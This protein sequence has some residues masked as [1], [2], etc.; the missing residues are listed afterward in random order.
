MLCSWR[1][2]IAE[3]K[4]TVLTRFLGHP[5]KDSIRLLAHLAHVD[6]RRWLRS[7]RESEAEAKTKKGK[8]VDVTN[9]EHFL[10]TPV[11][12]WFLTCGELCIMEAGCSEAST[13]G[14]WEEPRHQ[15]G[16]AS[17]LHMGLTLF[18]RRDVVFEQGAGN[19]CPRPSGGDAPRHMGCPGPCFSWLPFG[20]LG[21]G[22]LID[23]CAPGPGRPRYSTV[24]YSTVPYDTLAHPI[25]SMKVDG[26]AGS[27]GS[28]VLAWWKPTAGT[29]SMSS[30]PRGPG[31]ADRTRF[32]RARENRTRDAARLGPWA[33]GVFVVN[34]LIGW[35]PLRWK[36]CLR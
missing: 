5:G 32:H 10:E 14:L 21:A 28:R 23:P 25:G 7:L 24:Q 20:V 12:K 15:D 36:A 11:T 33:W 8:K 2:G 18:G 4:I 16:G 17:V 35:R 9:V 30:R 26:I 29:G 3:G 34:L 31:V 27:T 1:A 22:G 13:K 6:A 19:R